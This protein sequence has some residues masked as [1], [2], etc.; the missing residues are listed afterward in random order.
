MVVSLAAAR[1]SGARKLKSAAHA[2]AIAVD[3]PK[4]RRRLIFCI[5]RRMTVC[6][7]SV[8][9][10][11]C[12]SFVKELTQQRF[13]NRATLGLLLSQSLWAARVGSTREKQ[14]PI[15]LSR[16]HELPA[17]K[18]LSHH[19]RCLRRVHRLAWMCIAIIQSRGPRRFSE[20]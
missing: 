14:I 7:G 19:H 20:R 2:V 18:P 12:K 11:S 1:A 4:N 6:R 15:G 17:E 9:P 5:A 10:G 8:Q 13:K 3:A 16:C